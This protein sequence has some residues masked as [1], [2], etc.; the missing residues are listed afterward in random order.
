[1]L[2]VY[3][4]CI[5]IICCRYTVIQ[6]CLTSL[7]YGTEDEDIRKLDVVH[8]SSLREVEHLQ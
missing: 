3:I 1:M 8:G 6:A 2:F 7:T 4:F 5:N